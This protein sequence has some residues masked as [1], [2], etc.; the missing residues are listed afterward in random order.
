MLTTASCT[1]VAKKPVATSSGHHTMVSLTYRQFH[2]QIQ[3]SAKRCPRRVCSLLVAKCL[4]EWWG[5]VIS[6]LFRRWDQWETRNIASLFCWPVL[7]GEILV[8]SDGNGPLPKNGNHLSININIDNVL[9][10]GSWCVTNINR[11]NLPLLI[12]EA[13][14]REVIVFA[15]SR[16]EKCQITKEMWGL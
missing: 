10:L 12:C 15:L 5:G 2:T 14:Y 11:Q 3:L 4:C 7:H 6:M 1:T 13:L 16:K 8:E 9:F